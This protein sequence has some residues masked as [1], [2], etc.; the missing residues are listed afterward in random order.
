MHIM[1]VTELSPTT[2]SE[3]LFCHLEIENPG[4]FP[5]GFHTLNFADDFI[6]ID[7]FREQMRPFFVTYIV[8][9]RPILKKIFKLK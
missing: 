7:G 9:I 1:K 5:L 3:E 2:F 8:K 4:K 6:V